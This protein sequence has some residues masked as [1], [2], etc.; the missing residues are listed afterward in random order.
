[1]YATVRV[2]MCACMCVCVQRVIKCRKRKKEREEFPPHFAS[3]AGWLVRKQKERESKKGGAGE[4]GW[5]RQCQPMITLESMGLST[6]NFNSKPQPL[7]LRTTQYV[8]LGQF[9]TSPG[10]QGR[11]KNR[12]RGEEGRNFRPSFF[13]LGGAEEKGGGIRCSSNELS[14]SMLQQAFSTFCE[15]LPLDSTG[16]QWHLHF[17]KMRFPLLKRI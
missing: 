4:R 16:F 12:Q 6:F 7:T 14:C 1:M 15:L 3:D 11:P 17:C 5:E 8:R 9:N 10:T 2:W 13:Y